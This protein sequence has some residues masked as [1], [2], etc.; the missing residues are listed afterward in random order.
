MKIYAN[1]DSLNSVKYLM[2][3]EPNITE[4]KMSQDT[5]NILS[6][7]KDNEMISKIIN[8]NIIFDN[9]G[10]GIICGVTE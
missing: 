1:I 8:Y 10:E 4:I 5:Y 7:L 6:G 9:L 3:Y 2:N